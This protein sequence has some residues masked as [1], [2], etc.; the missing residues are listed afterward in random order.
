M[1]FTDSNIPDTIAVANV[2]A[3][4]V[5]KA[6]YAAYKQM[7][8]DRGYRFEWFMNETEVEKESEQMIHKL[9]ILPQ[10]FEDKLQGMKK[11]EVRKNDRPFKNGDTLQL[12]EW[13]EETGYTGR[14]LQEYIKK[15]Y[16]DVSGIEDGYVIMNTGYIANSFKDGGE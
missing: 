15:I 13:S 4:T 9:K 10:Y 2:E 14:L 7:I 3:S 11:W 16:T 1:Y 12:E 8:P 6:R 5:S